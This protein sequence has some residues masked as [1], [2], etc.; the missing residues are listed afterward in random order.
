MPYWLGDSPRSILRASKM[1]VGADGGRYVDV[2]VQK[3]LDGAICM[4][5]GTASQNG[6]DYIVVGRRRVALTRAQAHR[7]LSQWRSADLVRLRRTKHAGASYASRVRPYTY[8]EMV[9]YAASKHV[10]ITAELKSP[11]FGTPAAA[12]QLVTWAKAAHHKPWFMALVTMR[13][14]EGKAKAIH[15]AGGEFALLAHG[16][17]MP[18]DF[19]HYHQYVSQVWGAAWLGK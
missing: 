5:W 16:A 3:T 11:A 17:K 8:L 9:K 15:D 19:P 6:Y 12:K 7:P 1:R 2:N 18:R 14:W 13:N 10:T 4:H